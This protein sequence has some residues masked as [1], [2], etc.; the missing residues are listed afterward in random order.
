MVPNASVMTQRN[1][2]QLCS[3]IFDLSTPQPRPIHATSCRFSHMPHLAP[4]CSPPIVHVLLDEMPSFLVQCGRATPP[5]KVKMSPPIV[6]SHV[7]LPT[8]SPGSSYQSLGSHW[9]YGCLLSIYLSS[10]R[11]LCPFL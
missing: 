4:L 11:G 7:A 6:S 8:L 3:Y 9:L 5:V 1:S 2:V 10:M